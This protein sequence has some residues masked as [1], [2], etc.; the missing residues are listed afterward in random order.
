MTNGQLLKENNSNENPKRKNQET[1]RN[2]EETTGNPIPKRKTQN[3]KPKPTTKWF[4]IAF[5]LLQRRC[6][7]ELPIS[8][9]LRQRK[10]WRRK[11]QGE[12]NV[13]ERTKSE[14]QNLMKLERV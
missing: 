13:R 10:R 4:E 1:K 8:T 5:T 14:R 2:D 7:P 12:P 9:K 11:S 6:S 3:P